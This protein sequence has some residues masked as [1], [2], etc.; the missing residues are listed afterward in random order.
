MSDSDRRK[1]GLDLSVFAPYRVAV[2][3]RA[4]SEQ[5]GAAYAGEDVTI[6]EWRVLA[7]IGQEDAIAARD[8]VAQTPMDKMAVSRAVASLESKELIIREPSADKRVLNLRLSPKGK[9]V[10]ERISALALSYESRIFGELSPEERDAFFSGL[11]KLESAVRSAGEN[12]DPVRAA[13]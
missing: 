12:F 7:V 3:A 11:S 9:G 6:P 13:E 2:I 8:V 10:C 5:L 4:M 1:C